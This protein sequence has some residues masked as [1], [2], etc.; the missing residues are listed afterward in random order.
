MDDQDFRQLVEVELLICLDVFLSCAAE[1]AVGL[2][3]LLFLSE[4]LKSFGDWYGWWGG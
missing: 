4:E 2:L 3:E 1:P